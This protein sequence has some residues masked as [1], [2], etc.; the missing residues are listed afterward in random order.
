MNR[1]VGAHLAIV[2]AAILLLV[3]IGLVVGLA[4]YE[5]RRA[6]EAKHAAATMVT[7][8]FTATV[9]PGVV[10]GDHDAIAQLWAL[11]RLA[12]K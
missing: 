6:L 2:T 3:S 7:D 11:L 5:R 12:T 4:S 10:F 9:S 1:S 8:L